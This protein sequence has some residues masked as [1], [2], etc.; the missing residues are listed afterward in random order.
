MN[1]KT[2][3]PLLV[4]VVLGLTAM[5]V[6]QHMIPPPVPAAARDGAPAVR[7]V[8]AKDA[9]PPGKPLAPDM[10]TLAPIAVPVAPAGSFAD[11]QRLVDRVAATHLLPGQPVLES[12]LSSPGAAPGLSALVP[13]GMRAITINVDE[14]QALSGL[15]APGSRVDVMATFQGGAA[16]PESRTIV[17]DVK[18]TAVGQR[19]TR[20]A[21][22]AVPPEAFRT[23]TL[24]VTPQQ[25]EA[26]ELSASLARPRL[27]LRSDGDTAAANT[28]GIT[29]AGIRGFAVAPMDPSLSDDRHLAPQQQVTTAG[30]TTRPA[31]AVNTG[32]TRTV[33]VIRGGVESQVTF[34]QPGLGSALSGNDLTPV[35]P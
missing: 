24:V 1:A 23:V 30:S 14:S 13:A 33:R 35:G 18:V 8:V 15:V 26:I 6:A 28:T 21:D 19:M 9:I 16:G 32:A 11:P 29:L 25:A 31:I 12:L 5:I 22:A 7:V 17:Q 10:L 2:I 3:I 34:E 27:V 20:S 4:A